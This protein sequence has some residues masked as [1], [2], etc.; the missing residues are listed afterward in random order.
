MRNGDGEVQAERSGQHGEEVPSIQLHEKGEAALN[1]SN[2][3][4]PRESGIDSV[5]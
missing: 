3:D 2:K 4:G 5:K 1:I